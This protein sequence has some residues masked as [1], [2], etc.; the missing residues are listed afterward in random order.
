MNNGEMIGKVHSSM[1][2]NIKK[3]GY[4]A[5]VDVLMDLEV[6]SKADHEGWRFGKV[7]YLEK[8]CKV[9]LKKLSDIM[10]EMRVYAQKNSLNPSF[11]YYHQ[12]G[13]GDNKRKL[14][15]SKT[16]DENIEQWYAT[17]FVDVKQAEQLKR[18]RLQNNN[19]TE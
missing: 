10:H 14:R 5:P 9:N 19:S 3:K 2:N 15:F 4:V 6:H 16:G 11:T 17:H 8:V 13:K 12:W 1:Y 18:E 7:P